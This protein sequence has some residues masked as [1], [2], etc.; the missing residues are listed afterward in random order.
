MPIEEIQN[1]ERGAS[2]R[3]K[4]NALI[5]AVNNTERALTEYSALNGKPRIA[6]VEL[7]GNK[8]LQELGVDTLVR[9]MLEEFRLDLYTAEEVRTLM[10]ETFN[11][12][13]LVATGEIPF[14]GEWPE[15]GINEDRLLEILAGYLS[16][17]ED[18]YEPVEATDD[19]TEGYLLLLGHNPDSTP[20]ARK[21]SLR[22]L[23]DVIVSAVGTSTEG[24]GSGEDEN[25]DDPLSDYMK[26]SLAEYAETTEINDL[27]NAYIVI[28]QTDDGGNETMQR[29]SLQ[30]LMSALSQNTGEG[31]GDEGT[32][33]DDTTTGGTPQAVRMNQNPDDPW[34]FNS[35][36]P[37]RADTVTLWLNGLRIFNFSVMSEFE[38]RLDDT[39]NVGTEDELY[40]EAIFN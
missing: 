5:A 16:K 12:L 34:S 28:W 18:D 36:M 14:E 23:V 35:P 25:T 19:N 3:A 9:Q 7:D 26:K 20:A 2:I 38:I 6:D 11:R 15:G 30:N 39:V 24:E 29:I 27:S 40:M 22:D 32:G 37:F 8:T 13:A 31:T 1:G 10:T 21:I 4:L 17:H 33:G